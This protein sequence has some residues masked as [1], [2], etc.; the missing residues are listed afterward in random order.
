MK[1]T[2]KWLSTYETR[3]R[4]LKI[5]SEVERSLELEIIRNP[6]K[7]VLIKGTGGLRKIRIAGEGK[8][9]STSYRFLYL[10][11][12]HIEKT[13]IFYVFSKKEKVNISDTEKKILKEL[14]VKIKKEAKK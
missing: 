4:G 12:E 13:Y 7:G 3:A 1:R 10:D 8:G 6:E 14:V 2:F 9:K 5:I 11:L